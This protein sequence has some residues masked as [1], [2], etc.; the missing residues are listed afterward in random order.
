MN[1]QILGLRVAG[2]VFG[3]MGLGQF[4]RLVIRPDVLIGGYQF[5]LW[6]SALAVV[7]LAGLSIWMWRLSC[8]PSR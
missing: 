3:L 7:I 1:S 4:L 5:P 8:S 6:P 2:T